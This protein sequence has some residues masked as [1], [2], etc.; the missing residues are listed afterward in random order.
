LLLQCSKLWTVSLSIDKLNRDEQEPSTNLRQIYLLDG[1]LLNALHRLDSSIFP[2]KM[3][4]LPWSNLKLATT[5]FKS[6]LAHLRKP[7]WD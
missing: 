6:R 5:Q 7:T 2:G 3:L 1:R 4:N